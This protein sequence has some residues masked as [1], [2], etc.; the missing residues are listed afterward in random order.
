MET[1]VCR[2]CNHKWIPRKKEV[3]TCPKCKSY[4]WRDKKKEK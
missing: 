2:R 3:I 4:A 1:L